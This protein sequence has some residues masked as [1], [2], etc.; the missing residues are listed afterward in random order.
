MWDI[1]PYDFDEKFGSHRS[2]AV[3]KKMIRPGSVIVLHDTSKSC[4]ATILNDF[5]EFAVNEGFR[6]VLPGK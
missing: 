4:A 2:L 1:M 3:L 6:F 5:L